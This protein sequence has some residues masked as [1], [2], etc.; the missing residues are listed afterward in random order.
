MGLRY[1]KPYLTEYVNTLVSAIVSFLGPLLVILLVGGLG[2][3][4]FWDM[5]SA[6]RLLF[7]LLPFSILL[8]L[9]FRYKRSNVGT[10]SWVSATP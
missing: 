10:R 5:N 2:V 4:S 9:L 8:F 1:G 7:L 6:V 3:K